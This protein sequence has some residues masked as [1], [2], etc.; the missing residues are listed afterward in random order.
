MNEIIDI[1]ARYTV[2]YIAKIT[3]SRLLR[4]RTV[5]RIPLFEAAAKVTIENTIV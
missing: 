4:Y 2:P 1:F 5:V 3:Y